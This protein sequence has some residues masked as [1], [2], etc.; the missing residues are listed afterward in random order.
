[1]RYASRDQ[2][3]WRCRSRLRSPDKTSCRSAPNLPRYDVEVGNNV[4]RIGHGGGCIRPASSGCPWVRRC[5]EH[6]GT[7]QAK[8]E[9]ARVA[10]RISKGKPPEGVWLA[11][12]YFSSGL[13]RVA[14]LEDRLPKMAPGA[15]DFGEDMRCVI[16][17]L[18]L[19]V[20]QL[21]HQPDAHVRGNWK[22]K[23][24]EVVQLTGKLINHLEEIIKSR[25]GVSRGPN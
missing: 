24:S 8:L 17:E 12:F 6:C 19:A 11:G 20:D 2:W 1:M 9:F 22:L 5:S 3:R 25:A 15:R 10:E 18:T 21:K 14:A 13:M 4:R 16:K 23:F 7:G